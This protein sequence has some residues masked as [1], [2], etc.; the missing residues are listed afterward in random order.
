MKIIKK[1][2]MPSL[3]VFVLANT[4]VMAQDNNLSNPVT[5]ESTIYKER[6][7]LVVV[8]AEN[9][10][11]QTQTNVRKWYRTS[12]DAVPS[13][14]K[15]NDPEHSE[16]ASGKSYLEIL[17][18]ERVTHSDKLENAINYSDEPGTIG[19]LHYKVKITTPGR[20]YVWVRAFSTGS[21]DNGLHVGIDGNWPENGKR[22]QWCDGK[23]QWTWASKQR[24]PKQHCGVPKEIF[25]DIDKKGI[26]EI[27]FL[28]MVGSPIFCF[29]KL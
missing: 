5:K 10:Y 29:Q 19:I 13:V 14:G 6:K 21:E 1:T 8:E 15:D 20:Y 9:F 12:K 17:P 27:Q 3:L 26:H 28:N 2:Q 22:M 23:N 4:L 11:K 7:G 25:L 18:D 24:K 16:N